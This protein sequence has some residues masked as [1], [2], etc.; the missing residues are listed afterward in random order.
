MHNDVA[1][2]FEN[3]SKLYRL[4]NG[5]G[6]LRE[7][8]TSWPRRLLGQ[9]EGQAASDQEIWALKDVSFEVQRGEV[10]G[11]IGPNGAGKTTVLK[12]LSRVTKPTSGRIRVDGRVS[13]LIELGAGFHPDLTGRENIFL[14]GV[15]LGLSQAEI[16]RKF[17]SIVTFSGLEEFIDTP[18]KRYSSG[19]YV[20]LGFAVA[21]HVDPEILLVDEVLAVGDNEF[22]VRCV[23]RFKELQAKGVTTV[24]VSHNR[25]L[26][27][28]IC[29]RT[30]YLRRGQVVYDGEPSTAWD[31]Y[32]STSA[33]E[34]LG[35]PD[36]RNNQPINAEIVITSADVLDQHGEPKLFFTPGEPMWARIAFEVHGYVENPVFYARLFRDGNLVH[37]TNSARFQIEGK[38]RLGDRGTACIVYDALHLLQGTYELRTGVQKSFYSGA[39]FDQAPSVFITVSSGFRHGVGLVHL[40]HKWHVTKAEPGTDAYLTKMS[41]QLKGEL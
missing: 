21:A 2:R 26:I 7:A 33:A 15:I 6:S 37:G 29:T 40:K 22:R 19:M 10:L 11:F 9:N 28:S 12:L 1:L 41:R 31:T 35:L 38:Y 34:R 8:L 30:L 18:V 13:S 16:A 39:S 17:D 4:G 27:E 20:R 32:L 24:I 14:N 25:H 23:D 36:G 3:V 5:Q